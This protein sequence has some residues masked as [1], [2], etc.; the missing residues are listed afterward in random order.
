MVP[1]YNINLLL[2][3]HLRLQSCARCSLEHLN[4]Q[5]T[6][7]AKARLEPEITASVV[8]H[9]VLLQAKEGRKESLQHPWQPTRLNGWNSV[10]SLL[11]SLCSTS[12]TNQTEE[13][14]EPPARCSTNITSQA[15]IAGQGSV[16]AH[17]H[18]H[19]EQSSTQED[20]LPSGHALEMLQ[21]RPRHSKHHAPN[22]LPCQQRHPKPEG[23]STKLLK[24]CQWLQLGIGWIYSQCSWCSCSSSTS[25][26][27]AAHRP[28]HNS[29]TEGNHLPIECIW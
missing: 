15:I 20:K 12:C 8:S 23:R 28:K 17:N 6:A 5:L 1:A 26:V 13:P 10:C 3:L 9:Q 21:A 22:T 18:C 11:H 2:C 25:P 14:C 24:C 19:K 29:S 16:Y 4:S 7:A 27:T